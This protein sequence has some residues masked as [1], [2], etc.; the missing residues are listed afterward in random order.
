MSCAACASTCSE[1]GSS[2]AAAVAAAPISARQRQ[3][4]RPGVASPLRVVAA[5]R[6]R[7]ALAREPIRRCMEGR[8][9]LPAERRVA[10]LPFDLASPDPED[11]FRSDGLAE[12][13]TAR[14]AQLEPYHAG[15]SV[16]PAQRRSPGRCHHGR[17]GPPHV[18]RHRWSWRL[19]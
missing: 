6:R 4:L 11:Q 2:S 18:R 14:L 15:L 13:L 17:H 10:V 19:S 5:P 1:V 7:F 12:T 9:P 16:V 8:T 3:R